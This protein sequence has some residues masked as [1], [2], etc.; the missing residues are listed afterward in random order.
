MK[1]GPSAGL[2]E[3]SR[4]FHR[5]VKL[6]SEGREEVGRALLF[7]EG[8]GKQLLRSGWRVE[9][10]F[11]GEAEDRGL[12]GRER[13]RR[14]GSPGEHGLRENWQKASATHLSKLS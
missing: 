1:G 8:R 13:R 12:G 10:S 3:E 4:V 11:A 9:A 6:G 14:K 7:E 2:K 5:H